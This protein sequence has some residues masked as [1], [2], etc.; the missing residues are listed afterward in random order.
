MNCLLKLSV[1]DKQFCERI[2]R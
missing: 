1:L 2:T